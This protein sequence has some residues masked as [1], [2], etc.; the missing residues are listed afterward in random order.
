METTKHRTTHMFRLVVTICF[1]AIAAISGWA[2]N[3]PYPEL[4]TIVDFNRPGLSIG[5]IHTASVALE[6][7]TASSITTSKP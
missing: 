3:I 4:G 2:D 6:A 1:F 7:S 5:S